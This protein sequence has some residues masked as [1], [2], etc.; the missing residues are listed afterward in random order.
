[1]DMTRAKTC[2]AVG[3][4]GPRWMC[5]GQVSMSLRLPEKPIISQGTLPKS[6]A[7]EVTWDG[8][9]R[10]VPSKNTVSSTDL[11]RSGIYKIIRNE[12]RQAGLGVASLWV[13]S[14]K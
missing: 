5:N 12:F 7:V 1:M 14:R 3:S 2:S 10:G 9:V 6:C 11:R 8:G 13:L 4:S